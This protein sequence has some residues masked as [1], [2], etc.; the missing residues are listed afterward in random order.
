MLLR[1]LSLAIMLILS[2]VGAL[3]HSILYDDFTWYEIQSVDNLTP[4]V[5]ETGGIIKVKNDSTVIMPQDLLDWATQ[6]TNGNPRSELLFYPNPRVYIQ[7]DFS[8]AKI[9]LLPYEW[10]PISPCMDNTHSKTQTTVVK[11]FTLLETTA[12]ALKVH[13]TLLESHLRFKSTFSQAEAITQKAFCEVDPGKVL[14]IQ[15]KANRFKAENVLQRTITIHPR[16][17][18]DGH[19]ISFGNWSK[20]PHHDSVYDVGYSLGCI[21]SYKLLQCGNEYEGS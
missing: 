7:S 4:W 19:I 14:Q 15:A 6:A 20:V 16:L 13:Y 12:R 3:A 11:T 10:T 9:S 8:N 2:L 5:L 21:T 17:Q 18:R 1:L